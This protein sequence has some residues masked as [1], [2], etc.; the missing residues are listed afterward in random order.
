MYHIIWLP[1]TRSSYT[2]ILQ[3][4]VDSLEPSPVMIVGG[5]KTLYFRDIRSF[6]GAD[7]EDS[8]FNSYS[9]MMYDFIRNNDRIAAYFTFKQS[10]N[11]TR[12]RCKHVIYA[13]HSTNVCTITSNLDDNVSDHHSLHTSVALSMP[14]KIMECTDAHNAGNLHV[15]PRINGSNRNK[16]NLFH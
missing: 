9:N 1:L 3:S 6:R 12:S 15:Y 2:D 14:T 10:S 5:M 13:E 4:T 7:T 11:C 16:C 8:T